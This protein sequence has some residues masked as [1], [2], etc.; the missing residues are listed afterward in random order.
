MG[1]LAIRVSRYGSR[2][3][4]VLS[5]PRRLDSR[6]THRSRMLFR[7]SFGVVSRYL[8]SDDCYQLYGQPHLNRS[9]LH[10]TTG[11]EKYSAS[12][13]IGQY[14]CASCTITFNRSGFIANGVCRGAGA[15][16]SCTCPNVGV[17]SIN[18]LALDRI[19][20][21]TPSKEGVATLG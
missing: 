4:G 17:R 11:G 3:C 8:T 1:Q 20:R 7:V 14:S 13:A 10:M 6:D 19:M 15:L 12:C 2:G 16:P 21:R 5:H 9:P 18:C